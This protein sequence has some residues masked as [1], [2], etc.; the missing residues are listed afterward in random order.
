MKKIN[1]FRAPKGNCM[2]HVDTGMKSEAIILI[3]FTICYISLQ[4]VEST[5]QTHQASNGTYNLQ[6]TDQVIC[7]D[8]WP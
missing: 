7:S 4:K 2:L 6:P 5:P 1:N 3:N 8:F